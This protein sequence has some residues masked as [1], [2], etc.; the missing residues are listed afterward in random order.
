MRWRI[1]RPMVNRCRFVRS[2]RWRGS[3]LGFKIVHA[4]RNWKACSDRFCQRDLDPYGAR[5]SAAAVP[6]VVSAAP[7][8]AGH[9][10]VGV[11]DRRMGAHAGDPPADRAGADAARV[12]LHLS[13]VRQCPAGGAARSRSSSGGRGVRRVAGLVSADRAGAADRRWCDPRLRARQRPAPGLGHVR[14]RLL[15]RRA[16]RDFRRDQ[17]FSRRPRAG[18]TGRRGNAPTRRSSNATDGPTSWSCR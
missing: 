10:P 15:R 13:F 6:V 8:A 16:L 4:V 11:A 17:Q 3:M 12:H 5:A 9:C 1:P 18:R 2:T 14:G 7:T